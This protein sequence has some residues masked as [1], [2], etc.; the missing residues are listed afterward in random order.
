MVADLLAT[1]KGGE[2]LSSTIDRL[3]NEIRKVAESEDSIFGKFRGLLRS[4]QGVIPDETQRYQAAIKALSTTSKLGLPEIIKAVNDQAGELK[5][6]EKSL[7]S[8]VPGRDELNAM[9][10][11]SKA[12]KDEMAKLR[13]TLARLESEE[14]GI[15]SSMAAREKETGS[16]EKAVKELFTDIGTEMASFKKKIEESTAESAAALPGVPPKVPAKSDIPAGSKGVG[17]QKI[18]IQGSP[19]PM[20][21]KWQK[22]CP[23][24]GGRMNLHALDKMWIC[25]SCA[26]EEST[27]DEVPGTGHKEREL[28]NAPE[29]APAEEPASDASPPFA[30]PLADLAFDDVRGPKKAAAPSKGQPATKSK[31]CPACSK[32]MYWFPTEKAWRCPSCYYERRI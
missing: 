25:Y 26:H 16:L 3:R 2:D 12:V 18:E 19:E 32:K 23:M 14:A 9:E 20:D 4:F 8:A 21:T 7:L 28:T 11:R 13:E 24:C 10:A 22:K 29:P 30:V 1:A 31:P 17:E 6:L 5:I 27:T 15:R